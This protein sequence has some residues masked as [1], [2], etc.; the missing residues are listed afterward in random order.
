MT[1]DVCGLD[2]NG[3]RSGGLLSSLLS[4]LTEMSVARR[5]TVNA[6]GSVDVDETAMD[7]S[8]SE[9]D[10]ELTSASGRLMRS[11]RSQKVSSPMS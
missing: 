3:S 11:G 10:S 8:S 5:C 4:L 2:R 7:C 9:L 6:G 1:P